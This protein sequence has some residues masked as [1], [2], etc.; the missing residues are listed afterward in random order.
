MTMNSNSP[1]SYLFSVV[2][3]TYQIGKKIIPTLDSLVQQ[4]YKNFE[5]II[6]DDGSTDDTVAV[7]KS[8]SHLFPLTILQNPNWGGP[9]RPRNLGIHAAKGE[10]IAFL[11]HDDIWRSD[12]L[13]RVSQY[14]E[15]SD[16]IYHDVFISSPSGDKLFKQRQLKENPFEDLL[17]NGNTIPN[18][19]AVVRKSKLIEINL[20]DESRDLIAIEDF[21]LW[22]RLAEVTHRFTRIPLTLGKTV[23]G[24]HQHMT[25]V[26]EKQI[27]RHRAL[28]QKHYPKLSPRG[29][30]K[31]E[32]FYSYTIARVYHKMHQYPEAIQHYKKSFFVESYAYKLKSFLGFA[33]AYLRH[34]SL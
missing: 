25:E 5:V 24:L 22:L 26:S 1:H 2:I 30:I 14:T 6:S 16:V 17:V 10:F 23:V 21:D 8:Y 15:I 31:S 13:E 33:L 18:S 20:I 32:A 29:K 28:F 11:D 19:S 7:V 3:P 9:A 12:K 34:I 27:A 4:T